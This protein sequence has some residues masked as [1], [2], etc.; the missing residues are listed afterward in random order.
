MLRGC[1]PSSF[2][3]GAGGRA[4]FWAPVAARLAAQLPD[5]RTLIVPGGSHTFAPERPDEAAAAIRAHLAPGG[6]PPP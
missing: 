3:P 1:G 6:S 5:A 4:A 2:L